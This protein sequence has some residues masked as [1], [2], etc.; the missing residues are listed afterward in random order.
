MKFRRPGYIRSLADSWTDI[1]TE[2]ELARRDT[3]ALENQSTDYI[4]TRSGAARVSPIR[5][6][7]SPGPLRLSAPGFLLKHAQWY[8]DYRRKVLEDSND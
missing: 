5:G 6:I 4:D 8:T 1:E 2:K 7:R 3:Q